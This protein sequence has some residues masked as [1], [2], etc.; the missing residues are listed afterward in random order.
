MVK[1]KRRTKRTA[2]GRTV[3][4]SPEAREIIQEQLEAFKAKFGREPVGDDPIFFDPDE[5]EPKPFSQ[6]KADSVWNQM[7]AAMGKAGLPAD[8]I[9][10]SRKTGRIVTTENMD[11]L[12]PEEIQEWNEAIQEYHDLLGAGRPV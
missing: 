6:A 9:Y 5:S 2:T 3:P 10:A 7:L 11:L 12:L 8:K 1:I 4:L